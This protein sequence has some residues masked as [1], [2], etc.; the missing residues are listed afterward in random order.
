M[1]WTRVG[2]VWLGA[3]TACCMLAA[4]QAQEAPPAQ[5]GYI[6][7]ELHTLNAREAAAAGLRI[8]LGAAV[9]KVEA[10]SPAAAAGI[11]R[12]DIL[13]QIDGKWIASGAKALELIAAKPP[14]S[15]IAVRVLREGKLRS[16]PV[17]AGAA[18]E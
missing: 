15:A 14:G 16:G 9:T 1:L 2:R 11:K 18:P 12:G 8:P 5:R 6:G 7:V 10:N 3:F 4:A 17:K 13:L